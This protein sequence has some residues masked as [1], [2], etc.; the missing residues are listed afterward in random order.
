MGLDKGVAALDVAGE[1]QALWGT[2]RQLLA[3]GCFLPGY[4]VMTDSH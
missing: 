3:A 1:T 2:G 4:H